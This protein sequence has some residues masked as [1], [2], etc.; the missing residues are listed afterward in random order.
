MPRRPPPSSKLATAR[1]T[2]D[3]IH[4]SEARLNQ[5][6]ADFLKVDMETALT[7]C[8][9]A[10]DTEDPKKRLRNRQH[11]RVGYDTIRRL[12]DKVTL[13]QVETREMD[14]KMEMLRSQLQA[15]GE[16]F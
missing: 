4:A 14:R 3:E 12:I 11:A 16:P 9:I 7:F 6:S 13:T 15:L 10:R 1:A 2:M 8:E 5:T